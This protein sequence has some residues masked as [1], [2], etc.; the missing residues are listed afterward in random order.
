MVA[1]RE[2]ECVNGGLTSDRNRAR[3]TRR[4]DPA[5]GAGAGNRWPR[6]GK[7]KSDTRPGRITVEFPFPHPIQVAAWGE[8]RL[9]GH[10]AR[11]CQEGEERAAHGHTSAKNN[12]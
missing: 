4:A 2:S 12:L 10:R 5:D 3:G 6:G 1:N 7:R 11:Q 8:G 9:T